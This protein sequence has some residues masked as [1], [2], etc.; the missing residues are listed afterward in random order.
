MCFAAVRE[1]DWWKEAK[2]M[3]S[4]VH[5]YACA[6]S[7]SCCCAAGATGL[8]SCSIAAAVLSEHA[9]LRDLC[10]TSKNLESVMK[11]QGNQTLSALTVLASLTGESQSNKTTLM[12]RKT[13]LTS[14]RERTKTI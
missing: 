9:V 2:L 7:V 6:P 13:E 8:F 12:E 4:L 10:L 1:G 11:L 5:R 3:C 14:T